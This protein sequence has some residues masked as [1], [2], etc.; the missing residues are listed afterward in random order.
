MSEITFTP[1]DEPT[2][3]NVIRRQWETQADFTYSILGNVISIIDL[4]LWNRS[5]TNDIE[6][7]LRK[8]EYYHQGSIAAFH[9][10]YRDSERNLGWNQLGRQ[11]C[12]VLCV[13][14]NR[15][16]TSAEEAFRAHM[17]MRKPAEYGNVRHI[18]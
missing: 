8:I 3:G 13:A 1:N 17:S 2:L 12:F 9:I 10:M 6:N 16:R 4:D 14:R 7:V 5:V 18:V 11:T 15:R